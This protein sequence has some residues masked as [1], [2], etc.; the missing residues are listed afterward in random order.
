M[1]N[2]KACGGLN[3]IVDSAFSGVCWVED[4]V[5]AIEVF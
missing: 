2:A 3:D 1:D 5:K 4:F